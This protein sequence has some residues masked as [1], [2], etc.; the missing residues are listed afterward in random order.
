MQKRPPSFAMKR[1]SQTKIGASKPK[2]SVGDDHRRDDEIPY[3]KGKDHE[4]SSSPSSVD[5][6]SFGL[7]SEFMS[8]TY[9]IVD[10]KVKKNG[11]LVLESLL[12]PRII[13]DIT[14][15]LAEEVTNITVFFPTF[16]RYFLAKG[17][18]F[19]MMVA[20]LLRHRESNLNRGAPLILRAHVPKLRDIANRQMR[21]AKQTYRMYKE[22]VRQQ[23]QDNM[24]LIC[25]HM[26]ACMK[27]YQA[28]LP[29]LDLIA[30]QWGVNIDDTLSQDD[31]GSLRSE[32]ARQ[33][34]TTVM[35]NQLREHVREVTKTQVREQNQTKEG[36]N[37]DPEPQSSRLFLTRKSS[38]APPSEEV[39]RLA[40]QAREEIKKR[41]ATEAS[42]CKA[43]EDLRLLRRQLKATV[44][45]SE[46]TG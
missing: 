41:R 45:S 12:R 43:E 6:L 44:T 15:T 26:K 30:I 1:P 36:E 18:F 7:N 31:E 3:D 19:K 10:V 37:A 5:S 35:D 21:F 16:T 42:L 40:H 11:S 4:M 2:K 46:S 28:L 33:R 25:L 23:A 8:D 17:R 32:A 14:A 38:A 13:Q 39:Q 24:Q 29:Q 27:H 22:M 34:Q 9:T 20:D